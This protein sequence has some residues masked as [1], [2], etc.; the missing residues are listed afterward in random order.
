MVCNRTPR[1][2]ISVAAQLATIKGNMSVGGGGGEFGKAEAMPSALVGTVE[3][4]ME[5]IHVMKLAN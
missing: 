3:K 5:W 2:T 1:I 4:V